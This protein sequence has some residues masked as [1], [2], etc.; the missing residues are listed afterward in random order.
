MKSSLYYYYQDA[1]NSQNS[2]NFLAVI[3]GRMAGSSR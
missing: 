1:Q 2:Q 3:S